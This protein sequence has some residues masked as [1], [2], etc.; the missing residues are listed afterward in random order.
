MEQNHTRRERRGK[1]KEGGIGKLER[2]SSTQ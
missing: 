2:S 1:K